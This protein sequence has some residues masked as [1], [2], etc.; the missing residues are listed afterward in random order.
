[1]VVKY[2]GVGHPALPEEEL[3]FVN[4]AVMAFRKVSVEELS[5]YLH[6]CEP[7]ACVWLVPGTFDLEGHHVE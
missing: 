5:L 7:G 4:A 6:A 3:P 2:Y 1:M